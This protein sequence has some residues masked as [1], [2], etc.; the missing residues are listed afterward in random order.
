MNGLSFS[1]LQA[2]DLIQLVCLVDTNYGAYMRAQRTWVHPINEQRKRYG[3]CH[4]LMP[5]LRE[6]T[7]KFTEYFR[8]SPST[9]DYIL[10]LLNEA[11]YKK[12]Q[13]T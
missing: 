11:I 9:F 7:Q 4:H 5:Q 3:E 8:M 1:L 2:E 12:R 13:I 6:D 10:S